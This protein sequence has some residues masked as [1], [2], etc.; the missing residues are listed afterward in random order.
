MIGHHLEVRDFQ[1]F[2]QLSSTVDSAPPLQNILMN[3]ID[4][5]QGQDYMYRLNMA[6]IPARPA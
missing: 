6:I 5:L 4:T 1:P 2:E 3:W